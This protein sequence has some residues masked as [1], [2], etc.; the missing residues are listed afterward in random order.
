MKG[1]IFKTAFEHSTYNLSRNHAFLS[2][3]NYLYSGIPAELLERLS[4]ARFSCQHV[5]RQMTM[6]YFADCQTQLDLQNFDNAHNNRVQETVNLFGRVPVPLFTVKVTVEQE[7]TASF[8][9]G[10][11]FQWG[12]VLRKLINSTGKEKFCESLFHRSINTKL[13]QHVCIDGQ[14]DFHE[15][16]APLH[17]RNPVIQLLKRNFGKDRSISSNFLTAQTF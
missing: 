11:C 10:H 4:L 15:D 5:R 3:Q 9:V 14:N 1:Q 7:L 2:L 16:V 13:R 17:T 12:W 6:K 8:I